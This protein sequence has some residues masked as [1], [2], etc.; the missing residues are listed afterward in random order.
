M[1]RV[2]IYCEGQTEEAFINEILQPYLWQQSII[3]VPVICTTSR[4]RGQK[5]RGG[6]SNY[7]KIKRELTIL[8]KQHKNEI[9]TTMFDYYALPANTPGLNNHSSEL[10]E[11]VKIIEESVKAD[12]GQANCH[13]SL[14]VHEF[15]SL[16]YTDPHAFALIS[17]ASIVEKL[18]SIRGGFSSPEH[19]NNSHETAPSKRI[20]SLIPHYSKIRDGMIVAREIG[21]DKMI[22]ECQHF[23]EWLTWIRKA[24]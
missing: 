17:N 22:H 23:S 2:Y 18:Q 13:F 1:K 10:Y 9:V 7:E 4:D 19:I 12:I 3:V 21:I 11:R 16:L 8:C 15:E 24:P 20:L 5:N 6:V 14:M